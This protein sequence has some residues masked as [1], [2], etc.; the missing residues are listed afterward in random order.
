[1]PYLKK[2]LK[3]SGLK[4][5]V[6]LMKELNIS[7]Q[8]AQKLIDKK[9]LFCNDKLVLKKNEI[10]DGKI[11]LI[12]YES[13]AKGVEI[14]FE[15][16]DFA[17]LEKESGILTHPNGRNCSY[18]LCDEIWS[19]WGKNACVAHRLDK[20]TSGL[21]LVAKHKN[22]QKKFKK[23]FENKEIKKEYLALVSGNTDDNFVLD[24]SLSV[25][26]DYDDIKTR[27]IVD[28]FGKKA[29]SYFK[30]L[31]FFPNLNASLLLCKPLTGRQ[32]QLRIHLFSKGHRILGES[33]YGLKK[34]EIEK[35]LDG[36]GEAERFKLCL[37]KR[38]CL[39]SNRL[40]FIYE[41]KNYDICSKKDI[42]SDF[43]KAA[44]IC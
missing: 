5:F 29:L 8:E 21:I 12:S 13:M 11:E 2:E 41:E 44:S 15:N 32:H 24:Y 14:V 28:E 43:L 10:L 33:L 36:L 34:E 7:M 4:A 18:S 25:N 20:E 22:S 31:E 38:L 39:H 42:R 3:L 30:K 17:V 16:E 6:L 23:M 37:A 26:K 9:R 27:V 1:M 35:I 19:L 40:S